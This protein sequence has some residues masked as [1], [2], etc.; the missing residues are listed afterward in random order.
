[1]KMPEFLSLRGKNACETL[2]LWGSLGAFSLHGRLIDLLPIQRWKQALHQRRWRSFYARAQRKLVYWKK[3]HRWTDLGFILHTRAAGDFPESWMRFEPGEIGFQVGANRGQYT[4]AAA[5][6]IGPE[7]LCIALEPNPTAYVDLLGLAY[8]N[9]ATNVIVLPF[10]CGAAPMQATFYAEAEMLAKFGDLVFSMTREV[11]VQR[12]VEGFTAQVLPLD[13]LVRGFGL[14]RV[15]FIII[16]VEGAELAVL[17]GAQ[18]TLR[19]FRPRLL[20]ELHGTGDAVLP[21]L[22]G[23]GYEVAGLVGDSPDR[24]H[25]LALPAAHSEKSR[26]FGVHGGYS[27]GG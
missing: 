20:I 11:P 3:Q 27:S 13:S 5:Q 1:M 17:Q 15:D 2:K 10:A 6:A 26:T 19:T 4:F 23:L 14:T 7:G 25:L 9:Q 21:F 22:Q 16:D 12:R 8:L 18:E 24:M